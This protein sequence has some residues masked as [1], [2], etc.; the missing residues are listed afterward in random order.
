M[1]S[2]CKKHLTTR[3]MPCIAMVV[4]ND[5]GRQS[6]NRKPVASKLPRAGTELEI[7]SVDVAGELAAF[8]ISQL[9]SLPCPEYRVVGS[10]CVREVGY[11]VIVEC[12]HISAGECGYLRE[13]L[14][15]P[16]R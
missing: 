2:L 16:W 11:G 8:W 1:I 7:N 9:R 14:R 3:V 10:L 4:S 5:Q 13:V 6:V 12:E 15:R